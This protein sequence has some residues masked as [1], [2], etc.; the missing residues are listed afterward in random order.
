MSN[1]VGLGSLNKKDPEK[2]PKTTQSYAGG[3]KSGIAVQNPDDEQPMHIYVYQD[4]FI[5]DNGPFRPLA[6]NPVNQE[7][8]ND[9]NQGYCPRELMTGRNNP[10]PISLL[11]RKAQKYDPAQHKAVGQ[12]QSNDSC[13]GSSAPARPALEAFSGQGRSL[14]SPSTNVQASFNTSATGDVEIDAS[15]PT[16]NLRIR[17]HNGQQ[18]TQRFNRDATVASLRAFVQSIAPVSTGRF[19]LMTGFPP[20]A[21][22]NDS[23]TLETAGA[24]DTTIIQQL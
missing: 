10:L 6:G 17:F 15:R 5:V 13:C 7:F 9:I 21:L 20:R 8:I 14:A 1:I 16:T 3:E 12:P 4:G 18:R 23:E 24:C 11:D 19:S 2:N 22:E